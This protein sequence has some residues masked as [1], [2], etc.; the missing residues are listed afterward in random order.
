MINDI[1]ANILE[2]KNPSLTII[3]ERLC[4]WASVK[5]KYNWMKL[6]MIGNWVLK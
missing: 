2:W 3:P 6:E 4:E 5:E 1:G